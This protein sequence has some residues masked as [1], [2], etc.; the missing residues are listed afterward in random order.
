MSFKEATVYALLI[1]SKTVQSQSYVNTNYLCTI[2]SSIVK[3]SLETN[4]CKSETTETEDNFRTLTRSS[5]RAK[6]ALTDFLRGER[7]TPRHGV[8]VKY[9]P[10]TKFFKPDGIS[11]NLSI[12]SIENVIEYRLRKSERLSFQVNQL[13]EYA[14]YERMGY[15]GKLTGFKPEQRVIFSIGL[16]LMFQYKTGTYRGVIFGLGGGPIVS[17]GDEAKLEAR[18][19]GNLGYVFCLAGEHQLRAMLTIQNFPVTKYY[20]FERAQNLALGFNMVFIY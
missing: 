1:L 5:W 8:G 18:F 13:V 6:K 14:S 7:V 2:N 10:T 11:S 12:V 16:P 3:N 4:L 17:I 15:S 9:S 19:M 20:Q